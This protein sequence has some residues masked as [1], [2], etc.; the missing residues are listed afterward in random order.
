LTF[1]P[2]S[3]AFIKRLPYWNSTSSYNFDHITVIGMSFCARLQNFSQIGPSLVKLWCYNRFSRW[4]PTQC[5]FTSGIG[6]GDIG[7]FRMSVAISKLNFVG[8]YQSAAE[9]LLLPV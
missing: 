8:I 5:N 9:M 1:R 2:L 4:R 3:E 7:L 6:M